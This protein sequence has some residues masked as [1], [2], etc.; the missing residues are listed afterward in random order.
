M[1]NI[2]NLKKKAI[3]FLDDKNYQSA[4]DVFATLDNIGACDAKDYAKYSEASYFLG[5]YDEAEEYLL[6]GYEVEKRNPGI[7][8][9]L[10]YLLSKKGKNEDAL[11]FAEAACRLK[12]KKGEYLSLKGN[13]LMSLHR[14]KDALSCYEKGVSIN[15]N[16][17]A[18]HN[19]LGNVLNSL[20]RLEE[21]LAVYK[22]AISL[23]DSTSL[24]WSNY[25][26][27]AHYHPEISE[28]KLQKICMEW[29]RSFDLTETKEFNVLLKKEKKIRIGMISDGFRSHPVGHMIISA[30]EN[31]SSYQFDFYFYSSNNH[32]DDVTER[33]KNIA[34]KWQVIDHLEDSE[35]CSLVVSDCVDI[36]VDLSGHNSGNRMMAVAMRAAPL[37]IKWVGGLINTTGVKA[38]DYLISD[39]IETPLGVDDRYVENLIRLPDDY[40]CYSPPVYAPLVSSLPAIKN[41]FVTFACFNNGKKIND[42]VI[43]RW[44]EILHRVPRSKLY[45]KSIQY[46]SKEMKDHIE[47]KIK[48]LGISADR[49]IIEG[50]SRHRELLASYENVDIALDPWPYSGGLT[51]CE[52]LLMGVPVITLPGPTFAGRH[53]ATHLANA[54]MPELVVNSWEDYQERAISL[55]SDLDSLATIRQHLRQALLESPVCD[56]TRF[57]RHF[58]DAMRA[59]WQRHC[60]GKQPT[61]LTF[62]K[63]GQAQFT[64]EETPVDVI[65]AENFETEAD[66]FSW[67]LPSKIIV[68][69][70]GSELI[71]QQSLVSLRKLKAFGIV[72][73]DPASRVENP[74]QFEGS[75]D[76]QVFPHAV[77]G[78]GTTATLYACLDPALS[79]T[80][81]PLPAEQQYGAN[82]AGASVLAKLPINTIALDSIEGLESLDWLILDDLSDTTAILEN[83]EKAL[84]DMLVIQVRIAFQPT[85]KRQ[86]NLAETQHWMSRHGFRLYRFNNHQYLSHLPDSVPAEIRQA[87][88]LQ[89]ADAIFLPTH[90][91]L[92][93]LSE[94]QRSKLA[95]LLHTVYGIKDM[96]YEVLVKGDEKK[97]EKYLFEERLLNPSIDNTD[98]LKESS[99]RLARS[100]A[101]SEQLVSDSASPYNDTLNGDAELPQSNV[102]ESAHNDVAR[103]SNLTKSQLH[104]K[105]TALWELDGPI[106]VVDIGANPIDGTPPYAGLLQR[107]L[108]NLIGFEPQKDALQKLLA[109]KGPN[110][111][112]L[113]HA[114]GTGE[115]TKLYICQASG[116]TSTLKPNNQVLDHFQGYPIW[117]KVKSIEEIDT[118]RLD[119]VS[120]IK[121]IDWLKI[122]IQGGE[123]NVF[124]NAVTK[125]KNALIIQ[126][127]V[128]FI[129]LYENQPLFAEIDQWMRANGFMLHTLLE[130]RRRLYAPMKIN[131]G[132]HQ[133]INQLTT[134]DA[135]YVK[136]INRMGELSEDAVK[137]MAFILHEAYGSIDFSLKL[138]QSIS[139]EFGK[140]YV[141]KMK[142][143]LPIKIKNIKDRELFHS[144]EKKII[145][146]CF[147]NIHIQPLVNTL[148]DEKL[149][150]T[151]QYIYVERCRSIPGYDVDLSNNNKAIFFDFEK[152][153]ESVLNNCLNDAVEG[154][155]FHGIFFEWQKKIVKHIGLKKKLVWIIWGGDLYCCKKEDN[156]MADLVK[157]IDCVATVTSS[158]YDVFARIFGR[159][160]H[161][162]FLYKLPFD[163][164]KA[165]EK[166]EKIIIVGN[167]GDVGNNHIDILNILSKKKDIVNYKI[168]IPFSYNVSNEYAGFIKKHLTS[169]GLE[170]NTYLICEFMSKEDYFALISKAE[171]LVTAHDRAQA[172]ATINAA[173]Y[174]GT[175]VVLKEKIIHH[176]RRIIN[177][178]WKRI[179][180]MGVNAVDLEEFS[181]LLGIGEI[182]DKSKDEVLLERKKLLSARG[183]DSVI[184]KLKD[185]Q[186]YLREEGANG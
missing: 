50:P 131:G 42:V 173:I 68:L 11:I 170:K 121:K 130:Q 16:S 64:D 63:T 21:S 109:M 138:L 15:P 133:G 29:G 30:L 89:S 99:P 82:P 12:P 45:L 117:G 22:K 47:L 132:I 48:D 139:P 17:F 164:N 101:N 96:A 14:Y 177:P 166:K 69:D 52:A 78:N 27:T 176:N 7:C 186:D 83:G 137:K 141:A 24:A 183:E 49:L 119:D 125:L 70:N 161:F 93:E 6:K 172:G 5:L 120:E 46:E 184:N 25:L 112:Y 102:Q 115:R 57:S 36:F 18:L 87:T 79:S 103:Y 174:Y 84:K 153:F 77:L 126:T 135:V 175:H 97:A 104:K 152:D 140:K 56:A 40:I 92:A 169:F 124:K 151:E 34:S 162:D 145:H 171:I 19:N 129:Q 61:A 148:A 85:H 65:Y 144:S 157:N 122:D 106:Y 51:T 80:L 60:E 1:S 105:P 154:V 163:E 86:P 32:C 39:S 146:I 58:T 147:N 127:E 26:T 181:K 54:G 53:S 28:A 62:D 178:M 113:P 31:C 59:I 98:S 110:E 100:P 90:E 33:F 123:L 67:S 94:N 66:E 44:A 167:S 74:N 136:D 118:V 55:A 72:S 20:G 88:E 168:F 3:E 95:F 116:M 143:Y 142:S 37:Q 108:V 111:T 38:I 91:R 71:R 23:P 13:I 160:P 9:G 182:K 179:K 81:E 114:V 107:G 180:A 165:L 2:N 43:S 149:L 4:Y 128:N 134:A 159:K 156:N 8:Y 158:D 35:F 185:L 155:L 76:V 10:A 75:D 73:F 41:G 150:D